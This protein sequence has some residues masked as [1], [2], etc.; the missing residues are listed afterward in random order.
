MATPHVVGAAA[1][2]L[3][4]NPELTTSALKDLLMSS[5]DANTALQ[6]KTVAG[7]RLM[8][9]K[10][11]L[12]RILHQALDSRLHQML[13]QIVAGDTA[14]YTFHIRVYSSDGK[15]MYL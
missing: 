15:E 10:H 14:E 2:V 9:T 12:M 6:G 7:T 11:Y 3:S 5:G 8:Y 4:V 13:Q 1:L